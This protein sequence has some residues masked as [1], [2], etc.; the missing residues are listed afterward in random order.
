MS[1]LTL[2]D[3]KATEEDW[4]NKDIAWTITLSQTSYISRGCWFKIFT[5]SEGQL[6]ATIYANNGDGET[7]D[8]L[9]T[10]PASFQPETGYLSISGN[11]Q[12]RTVSQQGTCWNAGT[13]YV[14]TFVIFFFEDESGT[15]YKQAVSLA[16][17]GDPESAGVMAAEAGEGGSTGGNSNDTD[18]S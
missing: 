6:T 12:T 11:T 9:G 8:E 5:D 3:Q 14:M 4:I 1:N 10:T 2:I 16:Y 7:I 17:V 15:L 18:A 13:P